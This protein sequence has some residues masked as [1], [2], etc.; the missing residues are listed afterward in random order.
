MGQ[1]R[2]GFDESNVCFFSLCDSFFLKSTLLPRTYHTKLKINL[3][4]KLTK[5]YTKNGINF[6]ITHY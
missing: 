2:G 4:T 3:S 6:L 5:K 1:K